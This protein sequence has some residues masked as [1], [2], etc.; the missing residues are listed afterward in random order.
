[1]E[2]KDQLAELQK[3]MKKATNRRLFER[4]QAVYL[5]L[6][7]YTM[8]ETGQIIGRSR[9]T[10]STY[11]SS[12]RKGGIEG[13]SLGHSSGKP[14]KL[15]PSQET[16]LVEIV[17]TKKPADVHLGSKEHWTL[18]LVIRYVER[19]WGHTY[20]LRGMSL[21]LKRLGLIYKRPV[22]ILEKTS[23]SNKEKT[24]KTERTC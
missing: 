19:E 1:M 15:S 23:Q 13:L 8:K 22:Y 16:K 2:T 20:S 17:T 9:E 10:V 24:N 4:Y 21:L 12:Y 14:R 3:A 11:V 5:Y 6:S 7:G 18:A